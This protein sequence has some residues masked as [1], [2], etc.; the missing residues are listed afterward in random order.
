VKFIKCDPPVTPVDERVFRCARGEDSRKL[1]APKP[2][3]SPTSESEEQIA[4]R[5]LVDTRGGQFVLAMFRGAASEQE[6]ARLYYGMP[7]APEVMAAIKRVLKER[8]T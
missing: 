8:L 6:L 5:R 1:E 4:L 2:P 7:V 3:K